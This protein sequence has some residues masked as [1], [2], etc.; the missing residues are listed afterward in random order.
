MACDSSLSGSKHARDLKFR[1]ATVGMA[2]I[3]G[4]ARGDVGRKQSGTW[5]ESR[6]T[7][8]FEIVYGYWKRFGVHS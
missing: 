2:H 1:P 5:N 3:L 6:H 4:T 7:T 8:R